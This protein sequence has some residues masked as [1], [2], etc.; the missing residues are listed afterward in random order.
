[1]ARHLDLERL[2]DAA[3]DVRK[4]DVEVVDRRAKRQGSLLFRSE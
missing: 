2:V 3:V 1:M 4:P